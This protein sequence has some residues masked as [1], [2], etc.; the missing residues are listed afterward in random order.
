MVEVI[1]NVDAER[2]AVR[3]IAWLDLFGPIVEVEIFG[4]GAERR[5]NLDD[6]EPVRTRLAKNSILQ[7]NPRAV[8]DFGNDLRHS[9]DLEP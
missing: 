4:S 2:S 8:P 5:R 1:S 9:E 3:S 6:I 7:K